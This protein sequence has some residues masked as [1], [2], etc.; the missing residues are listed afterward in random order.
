MIE[1]DEDPEEAIIVASIKLIGKVLSK[2]IVKK[3]PIFNVLKRAWD[4]KGEYFF[5]FIDYHKKIF[6]FSFTSPRDRHCKPYY[7]RV[8]VLP[9]RVYSMLSVLF[10]LSVFFSFV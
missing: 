8:C 9:F 10:L 4:L 7:T 1:I 2:N 5:Y 3:T 6:S